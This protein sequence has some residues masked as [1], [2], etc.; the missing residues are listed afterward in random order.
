MWMAG[1]FRQVSIPFVPIAPVAGSI[2][3]K[4]RPSGREDTFFFSARVQATAAPQ[5]AMQLFGLE[6]I[7]RFLVE[8]AQQYAGS[9]PE[10]SD[11]AGELY[12]RCAD[13][14]RTIDHPGRA[15]HRRIAPGGR[16]MGRS[17]PGRANRLSSAGAPG[18]TVKHAQP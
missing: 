12:E 10:V 7:C 14:W 11:W 6:A 3:A 13:D 15:A 17:H 5:R 18:Q 2:V 8:V 9:A 16:W 4:A 1:R